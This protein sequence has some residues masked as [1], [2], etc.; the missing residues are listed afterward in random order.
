MARLMARHADIR[1]D[2]RRE[3]A[4]RSRLISRYLMERATVIETA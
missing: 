2:V 3:R 1:L 4:P